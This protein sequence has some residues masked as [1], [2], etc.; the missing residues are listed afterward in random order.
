M[1]RDEEQ[2]EYN[3]LRIETLENRIKELEELLKEALKV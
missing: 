1:S 2:E 3:L